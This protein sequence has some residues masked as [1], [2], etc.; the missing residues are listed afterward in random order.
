MQRPSDNETEPNKNVVWLL[1]DAD[2]RALRNAQ[3]VVGTNIRNIASSR[4][5]SCYADEINSSI[6][7]K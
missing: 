5:S 1:R 3:D 2:Y 6:L 7:V 4:L